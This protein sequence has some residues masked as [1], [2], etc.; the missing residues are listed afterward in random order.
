MS[1]HAVHRGTWGWRLTWLCNAAANALDV[2]CS[3]LRKVCF[4]TR[5][6]CVEPATE[7]PSMDERLLYAAIVILVFGYL[8]GLSVYGLAATMRRR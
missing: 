2:W 5:Q 6:S 3:T 4:T 1:K 7:E 8:A